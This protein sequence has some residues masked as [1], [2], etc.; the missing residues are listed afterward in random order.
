MCTHTIEHL[1]SLNHVKNVIENSVK[2][3]RKFVLFSWSFFDK[4]EY[5]ST[6]D[7]IPFYS[8]WSETPL[9]SKEMSFMIYVDK[10]VLKKKIFYV[11]IVKE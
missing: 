5:L 7:L 8:T 10:L 2:V 11:C 9:M 6:L 4:D 1:P 3:S